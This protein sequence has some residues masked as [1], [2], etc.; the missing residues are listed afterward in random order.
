MHTGMRPPTH[1]PTHTNIHKHV[2]SYVLMYTYACMQVTGWRLSHWFIVDIRCD[3][4]SAPAN[5]EITSCNS[6]RVGVGYE[7]DTCSF[8]C[9]TGY[10]L[11]GSETRT[12]QSNG[13]WSGTGTTCT[14]G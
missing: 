2:C 11:T 8:T 4:L 12:C 5:G 10:E 7:R 13:R 1:T 3:D 14:N 6:G 9:N